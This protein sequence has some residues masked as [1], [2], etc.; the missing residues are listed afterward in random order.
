MTKKRIMLA[1]LPAALLVAVP[2]IT[3]GEDKAT[4]REVVA[5]VKEGAR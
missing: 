1:L 5:K 4:A 2:R 3:V